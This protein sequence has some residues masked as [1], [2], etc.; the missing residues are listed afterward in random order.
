MADVIVKINERKAN[1]NFIA[2]GSD[3]NGTIYREPKPQEA[4]D[5][6]WTDITA[7]VTTPGSENHN[8]IIPSKDHKTIVLMKNEEASAAKTVTF[9]KGNTYH[10][11]GDYTVSLAAGEEKF[12]TLDSADF[13]DSITGLIE[14]DTDETTASKVY[15][16]VLEVR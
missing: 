7:K 4:V 16:S 11:F 1:N 14:V 10:S 8:Y 3:A 13:V 2:A 9:L 12:V 5:I 15:L 6:A